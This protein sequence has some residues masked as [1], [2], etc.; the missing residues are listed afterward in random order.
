MSVKHVETVEYSEIKYFA[1]KKSN[2]KI[3]L[4]I[5]KIVI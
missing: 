3:S 1:F 2:G 4:N 5:L